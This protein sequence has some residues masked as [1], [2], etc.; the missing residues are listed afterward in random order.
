[1]DEETFRLFERREHEAIEAIGGSLYE[2]VA[3]GMERLARVYPL[4]LV[5]NCLEWY[6][7]FFLGFSG[8]RSRFAGW[9]CHGLSGQGKVGMFERLLARHG[10]ER[11]IYVGDR[12]GD[13][14]AA[15][16]AGLDFAFA[17]Y[18]FGH[19]SDCT[20]AFDNFTEL[21]DHFLA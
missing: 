7:D 16:E 3:G 17:R 1:M 14:D 6:L 18:G 21:V 20:V 19:A 15:R 5:S 2:G 4:Y 11:A 9:D 8:L 12:Q 13:G 10:L